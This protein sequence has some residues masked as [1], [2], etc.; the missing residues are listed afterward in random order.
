V[1]AAD[2][3][4]GQPIRIRSR[5]RGDVAEVMV[6]MPHPME[7]GLRQ[8]STGALVLAHFITDVDIRVGTRQVFAAQMSFAVARDPLLT[9]RF[10]GAAPGQRLRVAWTDSRGDSR[11]DEAVIG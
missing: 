8:D 9:F 10:S 11:V 7:T 2:R 5:L 6:L 1:A 4:M 3:A